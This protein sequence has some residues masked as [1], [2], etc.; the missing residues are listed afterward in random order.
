MDK[1]KCEF[2]DFH[3]YEM[4][5]PW[6][7]TGKEI[8]VKLR[9]PEDK[10]M[11]KQMIDYRGENVNCCLQI[12]TDPNFSIEFTAFIWL[13]P[14][15]LESGHQLIVTLHTEYEKQVEKVLV[16]L[17]YNQCRLLLGEPIQPELITQEEIRD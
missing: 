4:K 17:K 2:E 12:M 14:K 6:K 15:Q 7:P 9:I 5:I 13:H 11:E 8:Q 10:I 16:D 1:F 3:F